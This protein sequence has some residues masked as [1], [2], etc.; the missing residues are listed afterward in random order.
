M[1]NR[2]S[3]EF[4]TGGARGWALVLVRSYRRASA[5]SVSA[6]CE[7]ISASQSLP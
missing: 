4:D 3:K 7:S 2:Y 1:K 6:R 5:L